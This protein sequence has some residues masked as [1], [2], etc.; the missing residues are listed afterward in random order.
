MRTVTRTSGDAMKTLFLIDPIDV[1]KPYKDSSID[2]ML[3]AQT[4][5]HEVHVAMGRD[6]GF[7]VS[8]V[9][10]SARKLR[11]TSEVRSLK[12]WEDG[13]GELLDLLRSSLSYF[14]VCF[15]RVDPPFDSEYLALTYL[16]DKSKDRPFFVNRPA[17]IREVNEKL[18]ALHFSSFMPKTI[19]SNLKEDI[20][21]FA[22]SFP[23]V[24]LKPVFWGSGEH[25]IKTSADDENI[26]KYVDL[27]SKLLP[28]GPVIAQEF[29]PEVYG[30]DTRVMLVNGA[31]VAALGRRPAQG[32]FR[33]NIAAGGTEF[34][35]DLSSRQRQISQEI[36]K[37]LKK[38]GIFFAG[39]DMIENKVIEINVTSP[40]LIQ[41]LRRVSNIDVSKIIFDQLESM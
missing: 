15:V 34:N 23:A 27:I 18:Y 20:L 28:P 41:E 6:V 4:R 25:I 21:E 38:L 29:L 12:K 19:V 9:Y 7:N 17:G 32:D 16:L 36:G 22:R 3:E 14:D 40:T 1:L 2:L 24:V 26:G 30:G 31:P 11:L 37:D 13:A 33:A 35:V 8:E 10:V 39:V 5:G